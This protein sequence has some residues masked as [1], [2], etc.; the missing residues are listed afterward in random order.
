[1]ALIL[2]FAEARDGRLRRA[3]LE[4][5]SEARRLASALGAGVE[6]VLI[7]PGSET[8]AGELAAH[9]ADRV[10]V[11]D[12]P[13]LAA[14]ATE[15]YAAALARAIAETKPS[16]VLVPFTAMGKDLAPRVAAR[17]GAGLASDCVALE[18]KD[19]RLAA[20]RPM[21]GGKAY[22]TVEWTGGGG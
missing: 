3:S 16:V 2:T 12:A 8:L 22:A 10:H 13:A 17:V 6:A 18:V 11:F 21:Y 9:G 5:V 14:Y 20:R 7:G 15:A 19:G 4:V 1:M